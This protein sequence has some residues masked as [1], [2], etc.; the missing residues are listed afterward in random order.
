MAVRRRPLDDAA[1]SDMAKDR[2]VAAPWQ[3]YA[4]SVCMGLGY[5]TM[6]LIGLSATIAPWCEKYQGRAL[7]MASRHV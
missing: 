4:A 7:A 6:S 2:H 5:A 3:L 1:F